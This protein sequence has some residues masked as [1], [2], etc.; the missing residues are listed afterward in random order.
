MITKTYDN[1]TDWL[2]ERMN[3][4]GASEA[5]T[6]FGQGYS[7]QSPYT[8]WHEKT[9]GGVPLITRE[10]AE[11]FEFGHEMQD[12][13]LRMFTRQTGMETIDP[14]QFTIQCRSDAPFIRATLDSEVVEPRRGPGVVEAKNV[15][16]FAKAEWDEGLPI[17][18]NIQIQQQMYVTGYHFG[19]AWRTQ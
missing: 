11:R 15:C 5:P 12:V 9:T 17:K 6:L 7:N 16:E 18:H 1:A 3:G 10:M 19:I 8:L 2:A 13:A 14:G 4:I